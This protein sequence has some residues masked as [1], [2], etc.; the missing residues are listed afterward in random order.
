MES[1][2]NENDEYWRFSMVFAFLNLILLLKEV[3]KCLYIQSS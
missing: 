1:D 2:V 3:D